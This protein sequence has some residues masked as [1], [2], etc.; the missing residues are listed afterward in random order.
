VR[1][2][3]KVRLRSR[4]MSRSAPQGWIPARAA[5]RRPWRRA[6]TADRLGLRFCCGNTATVTPPR[7]KSD[8]R[9]CGGRHAV[10]TE[11]ITR[12][13]S[14]SVPRRRLSA[15]PALALDRT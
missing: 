6:L 5:P 14:V 10:G 4:H 12:H 7:T 8:A 3:R 9:G 2:P 11:P 13:R 15:P 1:R